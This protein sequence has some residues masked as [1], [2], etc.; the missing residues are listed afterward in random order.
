MGRDAV[1]SCH[2]ALSLG[3]PPGSPDHAG[4]KRSLIIVGTSSIPLHKEAEVIVPRPPVLS[5]NDHKYD[6]VPPPACLYDRTYL[7]F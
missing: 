2:E 6:L 3:E 7:S 4:P 1:T 5:G